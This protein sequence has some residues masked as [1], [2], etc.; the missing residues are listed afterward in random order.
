VDEDGA[1]VS[2]VTNTSIVLS[3]ADRVGDRYY[4]ADKDSSSFSLISIVRISPE[5]NIVESG[6]SLEINWLP[7]TLMRDGIGQ[8]TAVPETDLVDFKTSTLTW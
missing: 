3:N 2:E 1:I 6:L 7:F 4:F 5:I 8:N